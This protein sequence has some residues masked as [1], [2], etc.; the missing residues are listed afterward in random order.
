MD[1]GAVKAL[2]QV[3][4]DYLTTFW[5][6]A[7]RSAGSLDHYITHTLDV[8]EAVQDRLRQKLIG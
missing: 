1:E 6:V 5:A 4:G 8:D 3:H 2:L 7:E